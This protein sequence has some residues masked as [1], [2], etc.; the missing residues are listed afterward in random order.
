MARTLKQHKL[1]FS[2]ALIFGVKLAESITSLPG[3]GSGASST[4]SNSGGLAQGSGLLSGLSSAPS[5][6]SRGG[7]LKAPNVGSSAYSLYGNMGA[8][9]ENNPANFTPESIRATLARGNENMTPFEVGSDYDRQET[10]GSIWNQLGG[11]AWQ[12]N[13]AKDRGDGLPEMAETFSPREMQMWHELQARRGAQKEMATTQSAKNRAGWN[14]WWAGV[15]RYIGGE[16]FADAARGLSNNVLFPAGE[17]FNYGSKV[18]MHPF[19]SAVTGASA[20]ID[21]GLAGVS[22]LG[23]AFPFQSQ[24]SKD[25]WNAMADSAAS[26]AAMK[27]Y[28]AGEALDSMARGDNVVGDAGLKVEINTDPNARGQ[29]QAVPAAPTSRAAYELNKV[30]DPNNLPIL[31]RIGNVAGGVGD[32]ATDMIPGAVAFAGIPGMNPTMGQM[33]PSTAARVGGA[34]LGTAAFINGVNNAAQAQTAEEQNLAGRNLM[35]GTLGGVMLGGLGGQAVAGAGTRFMGAYDRAMYPGTGSWAA[36]PTPGSALMPNAANTVTPTAAAA[37]SAAAAAPAA[38][39]SQVIGAAN[40]PGSSVASRILNGTAAG[41]AGAAPMVAAT[42]AGAA[43]D[44]PLDAALQTAEQAAVLTPSDNAV[45]ESYALPSMSNLDQRNIPS[46]FLPEA[47][48]AN[49]GVGTGQAGLRDVA[50]FTNA[51]GQQI[52]TPITQQAAFFDWMQGE[53]VMRGPDGKPGAVETQARAEADRAYQDTLAA[54]D[55]ES[56][57]LQAQ[58]QAYRSSVTNAYRQ[59]RMGQYKDIITQLTPLLDDPN[60]DPEQISGMA[61]DALVHLVAGAPEQT[62]TAA[63][64][65]LAAEFAPKD[66]GGQQTAPTQPQQSSPAAPPANTATT[67]PESTAATGVN[68]VGQGPDG[69]PVTVGGGLSEAATAETSSPAQQFETAAQQKV[70]EEA[71]ANAPPEVQQDPQSF[72]AYIGQAMDTFNNM[73]PEAKAAIGIGLPM[74]VVSLLMGNG[75]LG[76]TIMSLLGLGAAVGGA[77]YGGMFGQDAQKFVSQYVPQG[78][79]GIGGLM[80]QAGGALGYDMPKGPVDLSALR[81]KDPLGRL[82][83]D[84]GKRI[85]EGAMSKGRDMLSGLTGGLVAPSE[86]SNVDPRAELAKLDQLQQLTSLPDAVAIPLMMHYDPSIK[87]STEAQ[88]MLQNAR[89]I[90]AA[91]TDPESNLGQQLAFIRQNLPQEEKSGSYAL[92]IANRCWKG[93]EPVP[94]KAPYSENSCRPARKK[95]KHKATA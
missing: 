70:V 54:T 73:P 35:Q 20:I 13:R 41:A 94:G 75:G 38:A 10:S 82:T 65:Y 42:A 9:A 62:V 32:M 2:D 93:Y 6:G 14:D 81:G 29:M 55:S 77:A 7:A 17:N 89:L 49:A 18:V 3:S 85:N 60:A 27:G 46:E 47:V 76:S 12:L 40:Q 36:T 64:Q 26:S 63:Q 84:V 39:A 79:R 22:R 16:P 68:A 69:Q 21:T 25:N 51:Q 52:G 43:E 23:G 57:A 80:A 15:G 78:T 87:D 37:P 95:K 83:A 53:G 5:L 71:Q 50:A 74:A 4:S 59:H 30:W 56:E 34:T 88:Q 48:N 67:Q 31:N 58:R 28:Y 19:R 61:H 1:C 86:K 90:N 92:K 24:A 45:Y 91:A 44:N 66:Q 11:R 33:L 8:A 72:G